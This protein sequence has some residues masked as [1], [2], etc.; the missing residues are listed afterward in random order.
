M[1]LGEICLLSCNVRRLAT[2]YKTLLDMPDDNT[3]ENF[4]AILLNEPMLSILKQE[5]TA[6]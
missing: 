6:A 2:F 3:D 1:R 5:E 4:Q